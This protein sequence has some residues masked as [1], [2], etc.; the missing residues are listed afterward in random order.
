LFIQFVFGVLG[1]M[2]ADPD[3]L[4]LMKRTADR[5]FGQDY[6]FSVLAAGR[7]QI[8]MATMAAA[9]GGHVRVGLEDN[10]YASKGVLSQSN[11]QQVAQIRG[12]V[13]GLGR[14]VATPDEARA[15]L[16]LKGAQAVAF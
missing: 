9:M 1:G 14:V 8:P 7:M 12:I 11:A 6:Q 4:G 10:L 16:A 2:A 15:M 13:E 5:L 3:M